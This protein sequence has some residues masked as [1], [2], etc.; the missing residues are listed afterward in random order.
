MK[1]YFLLWKFPGIRDYGP[2]EM[3]HARNLPHALELAAEKHGWRIHG[4][5]LIRHGNRRIEFHGRA[6]D[7]MLAGNRIISAP[8]VQGLIMQGGAE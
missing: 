5:A 8:L 2:Y 3:L 1:R 6:G 7:G 4:Q